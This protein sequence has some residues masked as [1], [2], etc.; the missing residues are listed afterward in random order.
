[1]QRPRRFASSSTRLRTSR[2]EATISVS[3]TGCWPGPSPTTGGEAPGQPL[4]DLHVSHEHH[5]DTRSAAPPKQAAHPRV[6]RVL[7]VRKPV[8]HW[9][10]RVYDWPDAYLVVSELYRLRGD[11]K[12]ELGR[13]GQLYPHVY[14][15]P[16]CL[17]GP[18]CHY[19]L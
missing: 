3:Q 11:H 17:A 9:S 13:P 19:A 10:A 2:S 8:D 6:H 7:F 14:R 15:R 1:R 4:G 5:V 16:A 18:A 12:P